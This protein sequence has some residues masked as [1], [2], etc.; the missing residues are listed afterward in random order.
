MGFKRRSDTAGLWKELALYLRNAR[1]TGVTRSTVTDYSRQLR[2]FQGFAEGRGV[3]KAADVTPALVRAWGKSLSREGYASSSRG[4]STEKVL[5]CFRFLARKGLVAED[6]FAGSTE[7]RKWDDDELLD[8][9]RDLYDQGVHITPDGLVRAGHKRI[10]HAAEH[11]FGLR[12]ARELAGI[13]NPG[14]KRA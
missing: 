11:H 3:R 7:R 1:A 8:A 13:P 4:Q 10:F 6:G 12:R 14:R 5:R 2:R 9:L